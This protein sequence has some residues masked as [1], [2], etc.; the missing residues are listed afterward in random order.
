MKHT[1]KLITNQK[2]S[3]INSII[4]IADVPINSPAHDKNSQM[5]SSLSIA[6]LE[7]NV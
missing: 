4:S 2:G 6:Y 7:L 3:K 1:A 5:R